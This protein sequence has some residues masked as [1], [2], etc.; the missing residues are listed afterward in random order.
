MKRFF[1]F[2]AILLNGLMFTASGRNFIYDGLWYT[3]VSEEEKTVMTKEQSLDVVED[4][5]NF[6]S[7]DI[8][9]PSK[10]TDGKEFYT[11]IKIGKYSFNDWSGLTSVVIPNTVTEIGA[12][13]FSDCNSLT[14]V[15][16]PNSVTTIGDYA[17]V[18]CFALNSVSIPESVTEIGCS[19]FTYC[20]SL[21]EIVVDERNQHYCSVEGILYTK[22][23]RSILLCPA[24][25]E[26]GEFNIPTSVTSIAKDAFNS[27]V[28]LS[29]VSIPNSVT[30]IGS[31]AFEGCGN[32]TS[33]NLPENVTEIGPYAFCRCGKITSIVIP[34]TLKSI[35][36][37]VFSGC[38]GL[39]SVNIPESIIS[40]GENAFRDC[41]SL[42]SLNIPKYVS[43]I[44]RYAFYRCFDLMEVCYDNDNPI[45]GSGEIFSEETYDKA[46]LYTTEIG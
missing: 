37:G 13:A 30:E 2:M 45:A 27:C 1:L 15:T 44:G 14:S 25:K 42:T 43:E 31:F 7:G 32:L 26:I 34:N 12:G 36:E 35:S 18:S 11:V 10:V 23:R 3:V 46:V 4:P 19:V 33:V 38:G 22:D 29:S 24:G 21:S 39:T 8:V 17:F 9:I 5:D 28:G 6:L 40:I 41:I 20:R 16:I